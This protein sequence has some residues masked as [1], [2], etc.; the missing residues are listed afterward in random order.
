MRVII[1]PAKKMKVDTDTFL[2][3]DLPVLLHKAEELMEWIRDLS[4]I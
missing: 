2:C 3:R 1:S 4:Y